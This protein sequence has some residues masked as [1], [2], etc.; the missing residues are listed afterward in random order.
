M[1]FVT[2]DM[3]YVAM[4]FIY[5]NSTEAE[6]KTVEREIVKGRNEKNLLNNNK[7]SYFNKKTNKRIF[8]KIRKFF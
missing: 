1:K 8:R 7:Q 6:R 4:D 5:A 3:L 2:T